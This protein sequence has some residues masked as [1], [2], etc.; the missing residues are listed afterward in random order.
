VTVSVSLGKENPMGCPV[1]HWE[2]GA[3]DAPRLQSFYARLFDWQI[4]ANNPMNYGLVNTGGQ[5]G[6]NGGIQPC[7]GNLP[8]MLT[9]YVKVD[10]LQKYLDKANQ[11]GGKTAVP[12]T[13]IPN[14]G[15]FAMFTDPEGHCVGLFKE[16]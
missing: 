9:F 8:S 3:K 6:I 14:I 13:P 15:S 4:D 2:I 7:E 5:G 11:L 16:P 10:D 1:I 12:P